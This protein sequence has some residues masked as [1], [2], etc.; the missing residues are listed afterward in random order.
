MGDGG[1]HGDPWLQANGSRMP[2]RIPKGRRRTRSTDGRDSRGRLTREGAG[3]DTRGA[4]PHPPIGE[5]V[6]QSHAG[7]MARVAIDIRTR[8]L[9]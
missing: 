8:N 1:A 6:G 5:E 9:T 7:S 3:V 2:H 4:L